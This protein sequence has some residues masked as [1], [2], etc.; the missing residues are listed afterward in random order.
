MESRTMNRFYENGILRKTQKW[1]LEKRT[2]FAKPRFTLIA[3]VFWDIDY[4]QLLNQPI[5]KFLSKKC[6]FNFKKLV[7]WQT[8]IRDPNEIPKAY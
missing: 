3:S 1:N 6:N 8:Q 4:Q 2:D 5:I 7:K